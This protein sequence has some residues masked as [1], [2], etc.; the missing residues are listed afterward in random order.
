[1]SKLQ[2]AALAARIAALECVTYG[3][4]RERLSKSALARREGVTTR[5]I[6]RRVKRGDY[7]PP[8]IE[9][10]RLYWWSD[11]YRRVPVTADTPEGRAARDPRLRVKA[12]RHV[13]ARGRG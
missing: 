1:M 11:S 3:H 5:S 10:G 13:S 9:N 4:A 8:E 7:V 2:I 6:D 12:A